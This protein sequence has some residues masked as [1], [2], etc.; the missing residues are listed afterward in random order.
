MTNNKNNNRNRQTN[1]K[2]NKQ[3][4]PTTNTIYND[5]NRRDITYDNN[6][7]K[8]KKL[9]RSGNSECE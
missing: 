5:N 1:N 7:D 4:E 9:H 2:N 3:T 6:K 8:Y